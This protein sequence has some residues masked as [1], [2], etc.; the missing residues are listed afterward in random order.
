MCYLFFW[1]GQKLKCL[2]GAK[3]QVSNLRS[4]QY[5]KDS[6]QWTKTALENSSSW[7]VDIFGV[8]ILFLY[9]LSLSLSLSLPSPPFP[10]SQAAVAGFWSWGDDGG[11]R[12]QAGLCILGSLG[13]KECP[14]W[15]P[16][17]TG[18][19]QP[20]WPATQIVRAPPH[21]WVSLTCFL[22]SVSL[23][24]SVSN[25]VDVGLKQNDLPRVPGFVHKIG[26]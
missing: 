24:V 25:L 14:T 22:C 3:K 10:L 2:S 8:T 15:H 4:S 13:E 16:G 17:F 11:G 7:R 26:F 21:R 9:P 18:W 19:G 5:Y 20:H 23:S 6:L 12:A 1:E